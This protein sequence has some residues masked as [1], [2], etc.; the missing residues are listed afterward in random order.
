MMTN[1][2][3]RLKIILLSKV[4]TQRTLK[5]SCNV[6]KRLSLV[7]IGVGCLLFQAQATLLFSDGFN[8]TASTGLGG[9]INPG[10]NIAWSSAN[11]ALSIGSGNLT[12]DSLTDQGGKELSIANGTATSS[13]ITFANQTSGQIYYSFLFN[14]SVVDGGNNYFTAL[15]PGTSA[16]GGSGDAID[17]YYYSNGKIELRANAQSATAG[18]GSA[19]T[20]GTTYFIVE[21]IDLTAKTA[22]LWLNPTPGAAAPTATAT[23]SSITATAIDDV[24]FKANTGTGTYLVDNLLIGTTWGD[25]T[26]VP[27]PATFALAGLGMLGLALA[28]RM[29]R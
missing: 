1:P 27:E 26:P 7:L 13:Y 8:Y 25:V 18:T 15:N 4:T 11:A 9:K 22:S 3:N 19:L 14:A 21:E 28:R 5:E 24:G 29:R 10:N 23:L 6:M 12:Y 2:V 16:P 17:V 20:I